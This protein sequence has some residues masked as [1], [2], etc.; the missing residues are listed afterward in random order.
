[1]A[2]LYGRL[3]RQG[4][5]DT[6]TFGPFCHSPSA[7]GYSLPTSR[8]GNMA[9]FWHIKA[10]LHRRPGRDGPVP[11]QTVGMVGKAHPLP[12]EPGDPGEDGDIGDRIVA[13]H[14]FDLAQPPLQH[15]PKPLRF[16]AVSLLGVGTLSG[17]EFEKMMR[18]SEK[19]PRPPHLPHQPFHHA[20]LLR[21]GLRPKLTR[22]L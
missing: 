14:I 9:V 21:E 12:M 6:R 15:L 13:R 20:P 18:L 2:R 16:L 7:S 3:S 17:V 5:Q 10:P 11:A 22:L 1:M 8:H 4:A 19:R